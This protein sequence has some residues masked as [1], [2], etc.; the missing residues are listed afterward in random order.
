MQ[1]ATEKPASPVLQEV[2]RRTAYSC[3]GLRVFCVEQ[4]CSS[5]REGGVWVI[6]RHASLKDYICKAQAFDGCTD[7][8]ELITTKTGLKDVTASPAPELIFDC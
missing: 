1:R 8:Q 7:S 4:C 2:I 5:R 3:G 6:C